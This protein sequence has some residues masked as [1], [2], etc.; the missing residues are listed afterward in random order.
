MPL[1]SGEKDRLKNIVIPTFSRHFPYFLHIAHTDIT[2]AEGVEA[3]DDCAVIDIGDISLVVGMDYVRGPGFALFQLGK[4]SYLDIGYYLAIANLSDVAAMGATPLALLTIVR[5]HKE[6]QDEQFSQ[7]LEGIKLAAD[8][9]GATVIGGDIGTAESIV[10][11]A[12][13]LGVCPKGAYLSRRTANPGDLVCV[14]GYA[15]VAGTARIYFEIA[16]KR[17]FE[18]SD[19]LEDYLIHSWRRPQARLQEGILLS[20]QHLASACQDVSDGLKTTIEELASASK[21]G[22]VVYED[23]L[24]IHPVTLSI[25]DFFGISPSKIAMS[26]SVDFNLLFTVPEGKISSTHEI[27]KDR[28]LSYTV[29]GRVTNN[30]E[31]KLITK[32]GE[33]PL[34]GI[35]W[36]HQQD[37]IIQSIVSKE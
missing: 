30:P 28:D 27:F 17:G 2:I 26:D 15:G 20:S 10:L 32:T 16:K 14:T 4:L 29:I 11:G 3:F 19:E 12:A 24:P 22:I 33:V 5:Y 34:P 9:Y 35:G 13:A 37:N 25:A 23:K 36:N 18:L 6:L 21:A 1:Y 8:K 7:I 31:C